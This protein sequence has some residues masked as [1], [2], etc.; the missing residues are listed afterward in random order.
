VRNVVISIMAFS[1]ALTW[2]RTDCQ[3][4]AES[5]SDARSER[6]T[7]AGRLQVGLMLITTR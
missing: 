6:Q 5:M 2:A 4:A 7:L 3:Y 1:A